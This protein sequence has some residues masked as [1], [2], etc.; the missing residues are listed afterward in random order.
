TDGV[1]A[2]NAHVA[3]SMKPDAETYVIQNGT[4]RVFA[5]KDRASSPEFDGPSSPDVGLL[6]I[7]CE[8]TRLVPLPLATDDELAK[9]SQGTQLGTLGFPGEL[10][11][12][13]FQGFDAKAR[14]F[15]SAVATFKDGWIGQITNYKGEIADWKD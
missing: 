6:R 12:T 9:L 3:V 14:R 5:L 10:A 1:L 2:T 8:G 7:D 15:K 4:G 11:Q 13:Y